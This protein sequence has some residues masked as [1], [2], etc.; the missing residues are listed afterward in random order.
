MNAGSIYGP[1]YPFVWNDNEYLA[2]QARR[3]A[4]V[5]F[6]TDRFALSPPPDPREGIYR[7]WRGQT[8]VDR[9]IA[10]G[11]VVARSND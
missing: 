5:G 11:E 10:T 9:D 4:G 3:A 8:W 1:P 6:R 2:L 7:T